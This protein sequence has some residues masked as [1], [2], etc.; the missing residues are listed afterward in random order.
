MY[1]TLSDQVARKNSHAGLTNNQLKVCVSGAIPGRGGRARL[2]VGDVTRLLLVPLTP[3]HTLPAQVR[4]VA[5][6]HKSHPLFSIR[7][8]RQ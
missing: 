2:V 3:P 5:I 4:G 1:C 8:V 6:L 7:T